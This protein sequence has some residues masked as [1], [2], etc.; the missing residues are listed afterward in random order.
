MAQHEDLDIFGPICAAAEHEQGAHEADETIEASHDADPP[1]VQ[2]P[3][4]GRRETAAHDTGRV[5]G[6]HRLLEVALLSFPVFF[7]CKRYEG[8]VGPGSIRDFR[9]AMVGR[10][11]KGPFITTGTFTP[12]ARDEAQR[13]GAPPIDLIDGPRLCRLLK[14]SKLGV[15]VELIE[16]VTVDEGF[17]SA[18]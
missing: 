16:S 3:H 4:D 5:F 18:L 1:S 7:Q 6:T 9:G 13:A 11:D 8:Q 12:A 17:F 14:D 15:S 10:G 2:P